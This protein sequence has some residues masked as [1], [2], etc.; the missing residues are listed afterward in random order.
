MGSV[1]RL[2]ELFMS[3]ARD[4]RVTFF[5]GSY[6]GDERVSRGGGVASEG[7]DIEVLEVTLT[8]ALAM[9]ERG[10]IIDAKTVLLLRWA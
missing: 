6:R 4:R 2:G 5:T 3:R 10:E 7:E 9:V 8:E 1:T